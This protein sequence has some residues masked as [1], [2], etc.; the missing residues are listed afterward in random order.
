M[1]FNKFTKRMDEIF[2]LREKAEKET[3]EKKF[4]LSNVTAP[5]PEMVKRYNYVKELGGEFAMIDILTAGYSALQGLREEGDLAL[6]GHRAMHA[7]LTR[8]K[9]H[10]M[11]MNFLAKISRLSGIDQLH[12]GTAV[13]KMDGNENEVRMI[14]HEIEDGFIRSDGNHSLNQS[15]GKIKPTL[16]VSS[17]GLHPALLPKVHKIFGNDVVIQFGGGCHGHPGGTFEGAKAIRQ[18]C[19][20]SLKNESLQ[21]YSKNHPELLKAIMKWGYD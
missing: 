1:N 9:K 4:Y 15:W 5:Y 2:K 10:G 8:N 3:G 19:E 16:S 12:I 13:G 11:S 18:A 14:D 17:V 20:A 21:S 6:H 7:A